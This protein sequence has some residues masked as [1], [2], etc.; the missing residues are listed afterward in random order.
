MQPGKASIDF[1][2]QTPKEVDVESDMGESDYDNY[3]LSDD[4]ENEEW[5]PNYASP[6]QDHANGDSHDALAE[7]AVGSHTAPMMEMDTSGTMAKPQG[8]SQY[9][10]LGQLFPCQPFTATEDHRMFM[11]TPSSEGVTTNVPKP[12]IYR[13]G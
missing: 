8:T 7:F 6:Q 3:S 9:P 1:R 13:C 5:P 12:Y 4:A 2:R 11:Q 10:L